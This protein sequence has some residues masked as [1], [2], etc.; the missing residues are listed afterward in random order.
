MIAKEKI[1]QFIRE[2][3]RRG[4]TFILTTHDLA[5]VDQLAKRVIVVNHGEIVFDDSIAALRNF[6]GAKKIVRLTTEVPAD[7]GSIEGVK[8]HSMESD[9]EAEL[10]LDTEKL[11]VKEFIRHMNDRYTIHDMSIDSLPIERVIKQ[12]YESGA[13]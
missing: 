10:E 1:R 6:L 7:L 13:K 12:L 11:P 3:N 2:M 5:D 9:M 4:V 8:V